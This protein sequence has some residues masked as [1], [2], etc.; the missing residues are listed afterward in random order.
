[1]I[2]IMNIIKVVKIKIIIPNRKITLT[3]QN[4]NLLRMKVI[5]KTKEAK[6]KANIN[7]K[8]AKPKK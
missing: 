4:S 5:K 1:M 8:K 6:N 3:L 2:V 7:N